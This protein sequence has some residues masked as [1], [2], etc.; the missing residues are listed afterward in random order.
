MYRTARFAAEVHDRKLREEAKHY[1]NTLRLVVS[2]RKLRSTLRN[3][4]LFAFSASV[5]S[6]NGPGGGNSMI[7]MQALK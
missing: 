1:N 3:R 5:L 7:M 4:I 2:P 6:C